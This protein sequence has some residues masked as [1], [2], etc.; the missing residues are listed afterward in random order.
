MLQ[1]DPRVL[2]YRRIVRLCT[3]QMNAQLRKEIR[4]HKA[5]GGRGQCNKDCRSNPVCRELRP[6]KALGAK[7]RCRRE[8]S[9]GRSEHMELSLR[10]WLAAER[11]P[12]CHRILSIRLRDRD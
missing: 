7:L 8:S 6:S 1:S 5:P 12:A 10:F 4:P 9:P 11:F 2:E 3:A